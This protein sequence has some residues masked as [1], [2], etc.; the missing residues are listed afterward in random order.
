MTIKINV[1]NK[2]ERLDGWMGWTDGWMDDK[3]FKLEAVQEVGKL[4]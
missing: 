3:R 2:N 1:G 4:N